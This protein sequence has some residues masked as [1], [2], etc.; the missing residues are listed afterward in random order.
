MAMSIILVRHGIFPWLA[1]LMLSTV[2]AAGDDTCISE[3][4]E[5]SQDA[6]DDEVGLLQFLGSNEGDHSED[7]AEEPNVEV[8]QKSLQDNVPQMTADDEDDMYNDTDSDD[9]APEDIQMGPSDEW[10]R[11]EAERWALLDAEQWSQKS[12]FAIENDT[13]YDDDDDDVK[14]PS[15]LESTAWRRR[16]SRSV[17]RNPDPC[18]SRTYYLYRGQ[19]DNS[20]PL[21]NVNMGNLA[22]VMWYL[23]NEIVSPRRGCPRRFGITRIM[24]LKV[25][26]KP[27]PELCR[28][29]M[30]Y[31]V[32]VA[33]DSGKCTGPMCEKYRQ[34]GF[35]PG[36]NRFE[37]KYPYPDASCHNTYEGGVWYSFPGRCPSRQ[38]KPGAGPGGKSA[39]CARREP[40]GKCWHPDGTKSCTWSVQHAGF[41]KVDDLVGI[42]PDHTSFCRRGCQEYNRGTNRG[43]CINF[44]NDK[45]NNKR[46]NLRVKMAQDLFEKKYGKDN[47]DAAPP[48]DFNFHHFTHR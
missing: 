32:R 21:E 7:D 47:V 37:Q 29:G 19:N 20:F 26:T 1:F 14:E 18:A 31:G 42:K 5:G 4:C 43:R 44:W 8:V 33:Y 9:N 45:Y 11:N 23:H 35:I 22:G 48:C 40:G 39:S 28:K 24:R 3:N 46:N 15:L 34:Y 10:Y 17:P 6:E 13:V 30:H 25:T 41:I 38:F 36:C 16:R 27:T 12:T 2:V